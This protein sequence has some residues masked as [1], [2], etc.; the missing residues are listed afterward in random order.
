[1]RFVGGERA[2]ILTLV[3]ALAAGACS[4]RARSAPPAPPPSS[5][6][7]SPPGP[8][9]AAPPGPGAAAASGFAAPATPAL[10]ALQHDLSALFGRGAV[11]H[12]QLAVSVR[13]L[14]TG[15]TLFALN[16]RRMMVPASNQKL[17]TVAAAARRLGWN[18][19]YTTRVLATGRVKADGTLD[20]DLVI[21]G[22]G[23]PTINPRHPD[24]WAV[25]DDWAGQ[26]AARGV[27]VVNGHLIGDDNAF[28]EPGIGSGWSWDDLVTG[29]GSPIGALQYN[30][31]QVELLVGPGMTA[32]APGI[33]SMSP[34]GSGLIVDNQVETAAVDQPTRVS[35][36]RMPGWNM[37]AVRG[38]VA[39]G[40]TPRRVL[41]AVENPTTLFL[42]AFREAL[43]RK[44][45]FVG[46]SA[47]DIDDVRTPPDLTTAETWVTDQS[48][49]LFTIVDPLLKRSRN[50]YAET[51][52]WTLSP[53]GEPAS[54]V[55][56]LKVLREALT[57]LGVNPAL[58]ASF[59]GSGL[60]RYDM[61]TA[62]AL[63][64]VLTAIWRDPLMLGPYR[65][66]LPVAGMAGSIENRLKGTPAAG[67]VWA[68]TGSMFNINT[69]SGYVLT[70]DNDTLAFS[71]LAN[72]YTV[73]SSEIDAL[74]D[75][76]LL[77]L[78]GFSRR[79]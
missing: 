18:Y 17:L 30:E 34:L 15:E 65:N 27:K 10:A 79:R 32:G 63:T 31:N 46:G 12:A 28:A 39:I 76:A 75:E 24:R 59:D 33:I 35:T 78:A 1:V 56:G 20:G 53:P 41:A 60:S 22:S 47:L 26:I 64:Q 68:K 43:S 70:A 21:V 77:K 44:G 23:D 42:S 62:E 29:Y 14:T 37:I 16:E 48:L 74:M 50:G 6:A 4:S 71:F 7:A 38:Q 13:S 57:E 58:Y 52:L 36:A 9:M 3:T 19:R 49:P 55:A 73:P 40:A 25:L 67:R 54:D 66:A 2:V 51:L 61:L 8:A 72:N 69:L 45:I 5:T 11:D